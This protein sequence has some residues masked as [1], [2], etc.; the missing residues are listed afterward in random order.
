[1]HDRIRLDELTEL[2]IVLAA[3]HV[4]QADVV[5]CFVAGVADGAE[6]RAD[7]VVAGPL[8]VAAFAEG[9]EAQLVEHLAVLPREQVR[10]AKMV[11][12]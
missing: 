11:G 8:R 5:V 4:D 2:R 3:A 1:L 7:G 12:E 9:G 6:G 10:R